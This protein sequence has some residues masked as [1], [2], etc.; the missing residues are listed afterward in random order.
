MI[1]INEKSDC[2]LSSET[3][4]FLLKNKFARGTITINS[5]IK[6]NYENAHKLFIFFFIFYKNNIGI[7][8]EDSFKTREQLRSIE[9]T[10]VMS[11]IFKI[12]EKAYSNF[13]KDLKLFN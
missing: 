11:S 6:F 4:L 9:N 10:A 13:E 3:L 7:Y 12:N 1:D 5:R 8:V 2:E